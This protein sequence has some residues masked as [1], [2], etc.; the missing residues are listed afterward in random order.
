MNDSLFDLKITLKNIFFSNFIQFSF[1]LKYNIIENYKSQFLNFIPL[2]NED[3]FL[4]YYCI[5]L[6]NLYFLNIE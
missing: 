1:L 5:N 2:E 3:I 4:V 6:E